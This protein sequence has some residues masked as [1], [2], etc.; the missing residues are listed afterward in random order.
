MVG[1]RNPAHC[2]SV[3]DHLDDL[4]LPPQPCRVKLAVE[5]N[6]GA[7]KSTFL[8]IMSD[9]QLELQDIVEIVPEPVDEWRRVKNGGDEPINLLDRFYQDPKRYAYTFQHYVLL[10]RMEKDRLSRASPKPLRILERSIFSDRMV[11][12]RA[13]HEAGFMGDLELLVYDSW[14]AMEIAQDRE[15]AP[16]GFIYLK[17]RPETCIKRLRT[18]NRSEEAGVDAAYLENLHEKHESWLH[19]GARH[20]NEY[21]KDPMPGSSLENG[22]PL[23]H[24]KTKLVHE[25]YG[26]G[27]SPALASTSPDGRRLHLGIPGVDILKSAPP[28]IRDNIVF[29]GADGRPVHGSIINGGSDVEGRKISGLLAG[30]PALVLDHEQDDILRDPDARQDYARKVKD[31]SEFVG[32]IRGKS[33][34]GLELDRTNAMPGVSSLSSSGMSLSSDQVVSLKKLLRE[35]RR[36]VELQ[37]KQSN[38]MEGDLLILEGQLDR[39]AVRAD[40]I[41]LAS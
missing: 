32:S 12:V 7:G 27:V 9:G 20:L 6:I 40:S 5:G 2:R 15:L 39:V 14:F 26:L 13:M 33:L 11:F 1:F 24:T 28:S 36:F 4:F 34:G 21:L 31:F 22:S 29:L 35:Y 17:A 23:L 10:T 19:F 25:P 8:N 30:V 38:A 18:R 3:A 16:D 37:K 41:A